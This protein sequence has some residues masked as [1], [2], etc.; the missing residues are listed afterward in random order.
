MRSR[1]LRLLPANSS[2]CS[3]SARHRASH[4]SVGRDL[5]HGTEVAVLHQHVSE[6]ACRLL[7]R[8]SQPRNP[9]PRAHRVSPSANVMDAALL[10][11][12]TR[13]T[14]SQQETLTWTG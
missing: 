5:A 6:R 9:C 4:A 3:V 11:C 14:D 13:S 12:R 7:R 1:P 10:R 2:S 8:R